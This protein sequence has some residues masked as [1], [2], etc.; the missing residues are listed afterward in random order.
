MTDRPL[1]LEAGFIDGY[2]AL[3]AEDTVAARRVLTAVKGLV[4]NPTPE[5][6]VHWGDS[7]IYR[8]HVGDYRVMYEVDD[9]VRVWSLGSVPR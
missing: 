5:G 8:L 9:V 3:V 7:L 2:R 1:V 4:K 6:S